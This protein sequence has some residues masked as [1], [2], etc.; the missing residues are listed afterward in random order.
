MKEMKGRE[1]RE[2]GDHGQELGGISVKGRLQDLAGVVK[3]KDPVK[4]AQLGGR[5]EHGLCVSLQV[6]SLDASGKI[7]GHFAVVCGA[8]CFALLCFVLMRFRFC[9]AFFFFFF[10]FFFFVLAGT[11]QRQ[12]Q[13]NA[14]RN[15]VAQEVVL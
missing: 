15:G 8:L 12:K 14:Q 10:F 1:D 9:G 5:L 4:V 2:D 7:L 11:Q 6:Q 3:N 13:K